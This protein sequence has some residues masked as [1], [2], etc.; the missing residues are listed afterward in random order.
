[1]LCEHALEAYTHHGTASTDGSTRQRGMIV[2]YD[3][4]PGIVP[5]AL[6]PMFGVDVTAA[7]VEKMSNESGKYSKARSDSRDFTG[8]SEDKDK[9]ATEAI[10]KWSNI[11]L[12]PSYEKLARLS[13]ESVKRVME[14][15]ER[16]A[17]LGNMRPA[18]GGVDSGSGSGSGS[19]DAS[20]GYDWSVVKEMPP[21]SIYRT[22]TSTITSPRSDGTAEAEA[23]GEE[24]GL[25]LGGIA[26]PIE[27]NVV[28]LGGGPGSRRVHMQLTAHD[29]YLGDMSNRRNSDTG[30]I[31]VGMFASD[32][33]SSRFEVC[34]KYSVWFY[35]L[36][37]KSNLRAR[38]VVC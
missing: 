10:S 1:M 28:V 29:K 8:D 16:A 25:E 31:E 30:R 12:S 35:N 13:D 38:E 3:S 18:S 6:L 37:L 14:N 24:A 32:V 36:N 23:G 34:K 11:L 2:N 9:R 22:T 27:N 26:L 21:P 19:G 17:R 5:K 7:W 20:E 33:N 4:L 15:N